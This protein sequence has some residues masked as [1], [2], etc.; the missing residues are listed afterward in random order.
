MSAHRLF[1]FSCLAIALSIPLFA[2]SLSSQDRTALSR[3]DRVLTEEDGGDLFVEASYLPKRLSE[4]RQQGALH[5]LI[6]LMDLPPATSVP[7]GEGSPRRFR[8]TLVLE[9]QDGNTRLHNDEIQPVLGPSTGFLSFESEVELP[10]EVR[11]VVALVEDLAS[12]RWGG[13]VIEEVDDEVEIPDDAVASIRPGV[14]ALAG[15]DGGAPP[16]VATSAPPPAAPS[17]SAPAPAPQPSPATASAP[18]AAAAPALGPSSVLRLLPPRG[19][20][21]AG[22]IEF[23]VLVADYAVNKVQ[24]LLDGTPVLTDSKEPFQTRIRLAG[25]GKPQTVTAVALTADG[26]RLGQDTLTVNEISRSFRVRLS[27]AGP[28]AADGSLEIEARAELPAG[29]QLAQIELYANDS[30]LARGAGPIVRTRVAAEVLAASAFLRATATLADGSATEDV[31]LLTEGVLAESV[32]VNLVEVYTVVTD[33]DGRPVRELAPKDFEVRLGG[34]PQ[35]LERASF[36]TDVPL[37]L[38]LLVD[39]SGSMEFL[40]PE[41]KQAAGQFL[42]QSLGKIDRAFVVD[43]SDRPR[44]RHRPSGSVAELLASFRT[45]QAAGSTALYDALLFSLLEF[46][47]QPGRHALVALTDGSDTHSR[48]GPNKVIQ[49]ARRLGVPVYLIVLGGERAVT[50]TASLEIEAIAKQTGGRLAFPESV[51]ELSSVYQQIQAELRSQYLL[52]FYTERE[53]SPETLRSIKVDV[54]GKGREARVVVGMK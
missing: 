11:D 6:D 21:L 20:T 7:G 40:L 28:R 34:K 17:P 24:F 38:G 27:E 23:E 29:A 37:L 25:P 5:L 19:R 35:S 42:S 3:A 32:E 26:R 14:W 52:T 36:A 10:A 30:Q 13:A 46:S 9:D 31:R 4:D 49:Y 45:F 47:S 1:A 22:P 33:R 48:S 51:E 18:A 15:G 54:T 43:F 16:A 2:Q 8:I 12:R 39:T 41:A 53:L 50:G 44:L